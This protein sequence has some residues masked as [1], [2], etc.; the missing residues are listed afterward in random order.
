MILIYLGLILCFI[1]I[2][3]IFKMNNLYNKCHASSIADS[4]GI[5]II[6]IG[7]AFSAPSLAVTVKIMV[8]GVILLLVAPGNTHTILKAYRKKTWK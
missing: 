2:F 1:S 3:G 6:F 4:F 8:L 7:L 5:P